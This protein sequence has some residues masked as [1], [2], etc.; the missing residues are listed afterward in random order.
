MKRDPKGNFSS[1]PYN[2]GL[3]DVVK[4][5]RRWSL[6]QEKSAAKRGF[7]GW[8]ER[9]YLPH[10]DAPD[11]TQF[12][13]F[14]LCDSFPV[15]RR[16]EWEALLQIEDDRKRREQLEGYLDRGLG[17]C[18]LRRDDIAQIVQDAFCLFHT[19]RY[20]LEAWVIMPNHVHVLFHVLDFPMAETIKGWKSVTARRANKILGRTGKFW[21]DDYWDT[22][23]RNGEQTGK[24]R[25]YIENNPIKAR[26]VV[27]PKNWQWSSAGFRD[28]LGVLQVKS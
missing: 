16:H 7:A 2:P 11:L 28:T 3:R 8:T 14:R 18:Y 1:P 19:I 6:P 13:T 27:D 23:M 26:L 5:K 10:R 20:E 4:E 15:E 9:G 22:Y 21:H 17:A 24:A 25:R 12:V